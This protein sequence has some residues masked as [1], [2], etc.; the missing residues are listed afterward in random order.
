M[1]ELLKEGV[2]KNIGVS[3]F[4]SKQVQRILDNSTVKPAVNQVTDTT[5]HVNIFS[6]R[7]LQTKKNKSRNHFL[8]PLLFP[9][10]FS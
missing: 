9:Y 8:S 4:N 2:V 6:W 10:S 5:E 3:N 7:F 1:E